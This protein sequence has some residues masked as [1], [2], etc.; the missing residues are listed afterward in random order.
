MKLRCGDALRLVRAVKSS[1]VDLVIMDLPYEVGGTDERV[2]TN[3]REGWSWGWDKDVGFSWLS[4]L[5]RV[6]KPGGS[7]IGFHKWQRLGDLAG[8]LEAC[9]LT[10]KDRL[11]WV[12]TN[13]RRLNQTRRFLADVENMVWATKGKG[14]SFD[15]SGISSVFWYPKPA[16]VKRGWNIRHPCEK[17]LLLMQDLV[18]TLSPPSGVVLDPFMGCGVVGQ[19]CSLLDRFFIGFEL[20]EEYYLEAEHRLGGEPASGIR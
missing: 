2:K 14:W 6:L 7:V 5:E 18:A 4:S 15:G 20:E 17:P 8:G 3:G 9:G 10:V 13:P 11:T 19:A 1:S 12:K 16:N